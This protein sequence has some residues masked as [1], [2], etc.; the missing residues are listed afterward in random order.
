[1]DVSKDTGILTHFTEIFEK[2]VCL[3]HA[4]MW[5]LVYLIY[6]V[7]LFCGDAD[8]DDEDDED[9][10]E[11]DDAVSNV[12]VGGLLACHLLLFICVCL[13]VCLPVSLFALLLVYF[14]LFLC[15]V[16]LCLL[17]F[18]CYLLSRRC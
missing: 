4:A 18:W 13:S 1:M 8:D 16:L 9:D 10:D 7:C 2:K 5:H 17:L 6:L 14:A 15:V 3:I 12:A 11:D